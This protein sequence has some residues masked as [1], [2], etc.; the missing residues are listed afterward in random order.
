LAHGFEAILKE[1]TGAGLL[2]LI[3]FGFL[4]QVDAKETQSY[5]SLISAGAA[6]LAEDDLD[7]AMNYFIRAS[8]V[9]R[10]GV[11]ARYYI[12]VTHSRAGRYIA[13]EEALQRAL[14]LDRTFIPAYFE[15]GVLYYRT[16]QDEKALEAFQQVERVDPE[17]ARVH[18]YQGLILRRMGRVEEAVDSLEKAAA[19]DPSLAAEAGYRAGEAYYELGDLE[20]AR[21][22]FRDVAALYPGSEA[23]RLSNRFLGRVEEMRPWD[24]SLSAGIQYDTNV[25]LEPS[26]GPVSQAA[27]NREDYAGVFHLLG[28]YRWLDTPR[29]VG[30][31]QY[32]FFQNL[33]TRES[34]NDFNIQDHQLDLEAGKRFSRSE[35]TLQ[36]ALQ[37]TTLGGEGYLLEHSAGPRFLFQET[38]RNVTD[39]SYRYGIEE[40]EDVPP[41]FPNNSNRDADFHQAGIRHDWFFGKRG[42]VHGGY[43]YEKN[44]A[45]DAP[46]EDDWSFDGH[47]LSLGGSLPPWRELVLSADLEYVFRR[48]TEPNEQPPG[49][50][51]EDDG[52][53]VSFS[54]ARSFG[55]HFEISLQYLYQKNHSN[56]PLFDYDRSI[57]GLIG[58]GRF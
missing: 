36:Y 19:L 3:F 26:G 21:A 29:W 18:Y 1:I 45:G 40:F 54:L 41:L 39:L 57:Y 12:G 14:M 10:K 11:E 47:H 58:T 31:A 24:L 20:S 15:L 44:V 6:E 13:A 30:R 27:T 55:F 49:G 37:Y 9:N 42:N 5:S 52:P 2:L 33:H 48:F 16:E 28:R 53:M 22:R 23:A 34:L 32:S 35:L 25:V 17:R 8:K 51:R 7:S 43:L 4:C 50:E 56:I 38:E 46:P